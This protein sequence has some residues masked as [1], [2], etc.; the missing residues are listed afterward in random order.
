MKRFI[1]ILISVLSIPVVAADDSIGYGGFKLGMTI[2]DARILFENNYQSIGWKGYYAT[3]G[4]S[5][6]M[7][8]ELWVRT[9]LEFKNENTGE[10]LRIYGTKGAELDSLIS[11]IY[12]R[13]T[14]DNAAQ[15]QSEYLTVK[16]IMVKKYGKPVK[17]SNKYKYADWRIGKNRNIS[18][19][20]TIDTE[21]DLYDISVQYRDVVL[22]KIERKYYETEM[23]KLQDER[24]NKE[25]GKY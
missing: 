21:Y 17:S 10:I 9:G 14:F 7:E 16:E 5:G 4:E 6:K 15:V 25:S 12:Y 11:Y 1:I 20:T 22:G 24:Y 23:K 3:T 18:L 8:S 2:E 13:E 19:L